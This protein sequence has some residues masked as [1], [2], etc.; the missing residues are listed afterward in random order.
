[1]PKKANSWVYF[2]Q[3]TLKA[4]NVQPAA[5]EQALAV[6]LAAQPGIQAAFTRTQLMSSEPLDVTG[7]AVRRSFRPESSGDVIV[8]LKPYY[9]FSPPITSLNPKYAAYRTSHGTPHAYDTHVPL[10]VFGAG[11]APGKRAEPVT[12]QA[13]AGILAAGLA[14]PS[15]AG[16]VAAVP[17]GLIRK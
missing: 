6:W 8:V 7:S 11:V 4:N 16:A 15:P 13:V 14:L 9:I 1:M 5:A 12:P 2:N 3:A 10:L 17:A